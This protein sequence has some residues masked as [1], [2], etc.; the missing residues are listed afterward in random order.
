MLTINF[1]RVASAPAVRQAAAAA[2]GDDLLRVSA[3]DIRSKMWAKSGCRTGRVALG[4]GDGG[5]CHARLSA[6][7]SR[8]GLAPPRRARS[9]FAYPLVRHHVLLIQS[10]Y[11]RAAREAGVLHADGGRSAARAGTTAG[12]AAA[13]RRGPLL[14]KEANHSGRAR[15]P[16]RLNWRTQA[17]PCRP[18]GRAIVSIAQD[19]RVRER[20]ARRT[21]TTTRCRAAAR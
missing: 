15:S 7:F 4:G 13:Q 3:Q 1:R 11:Q 9:T 21:S 10:S 5:S 17:D 20:P 6:F 18:C 8:H 2:L 14:L 16:P 12:S 19:L